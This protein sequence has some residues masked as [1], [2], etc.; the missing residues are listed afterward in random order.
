MYIRR[1]EGDEELFSANLDKVAVLDQV[2]YGGL[3]VSL[4]LSAFLIPI[5]GD[6]V[7]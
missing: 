5:C 4:D 1:Q 6:F 2:N 7:L 3:S